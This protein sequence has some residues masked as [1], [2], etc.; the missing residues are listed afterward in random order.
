M[1]NT[2]SQSLR[3]IVGIGSGIR[4]AVHLTVAML[5]CRADRDELSEMLPPLVA[6]DVEPHADDA[7]CPE[8]VCLLFHPSHRQLARLIHRLREHLHFHRLLPARLLV[9]DM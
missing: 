9:T 5:Y 1:K 2:S 3:L 6:A 4:R 7:V 8:L